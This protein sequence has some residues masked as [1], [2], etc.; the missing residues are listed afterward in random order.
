MEH[1]YLQLTTNKHSFLPTNSRDLSKVLNYLDFILKQVMNP[2]NT[3][4]RYS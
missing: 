3:G 1:F 4:T 2:M